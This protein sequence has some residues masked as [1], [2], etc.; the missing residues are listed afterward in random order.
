[1][2]RD[3][4]AEGEA[5]DHR[6]GLISRVGGG[7]LGG[8]LLV[9]RNTTFTAEFCAGSIGPPASGT[10]QRQGCAADV[11]EFRRLRIVPIAVWALHDLHRSSLLQFVPTVPVPRQHGEGDE[12][13]SGKENTASI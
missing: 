8:R 3:S 9:K 6:L 2:S 10:M 12:N 4:R 11:A 1:M 7:R 5:E 13:R